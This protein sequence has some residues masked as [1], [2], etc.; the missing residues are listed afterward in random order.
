MYAQT[1]CH[2]YIY[3]I[4]CNAMT[5]VWANGFLLSY[6]SSMVSPCFRPS[7]TSPPRQCFGP[8]WH[9]TKRKPS[10]GEGI[11]EPKM[12]EGHQN[13]YS[14]GSPNGGITALNC[15]VHVCFLMRTRMTQHL[16]MMVV[17]VSHPEDGPTFFRA[18]ATWQ[19]SDP[20]IEVGILPSVSQW[21][22][23]WNE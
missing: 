1:I 22:R 2:I 10:P 14:D 9:P 8:N 5:G 16:N 6:Q 23:G 20:T 7:V 21:D 11:L 15:F 17:V 13:W 4:P 12:L 3:Y 18:R 19:S